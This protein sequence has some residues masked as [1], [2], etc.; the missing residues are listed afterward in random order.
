MVRRIT[1]A[2]LVTVTLAGAGATA[3]HAGS[4]WSAEPVQ[5]TAQGVAWK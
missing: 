5:V 3:A 1:A 2:L 4:R